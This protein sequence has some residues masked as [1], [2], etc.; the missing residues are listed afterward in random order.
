MASE[1]TIGRLCLY[2]RALQRIQLE[3]RPFVYSH[4]LAAET[5]VSAAQVRRDLM[6]IGYSGSPNRGYDTNELA[7]SIGERLDDPRGQAVA[8]VGVGN[9]GRA[10][11]SFV[12]RQRPGLEIVAAF[13]NNPDKAGRVIQG[14]RCHGFEDIGRVVAEQRILVGILTVPADAAQS[15]ADQLIA[16]GVTGLLNFAPTSLRVPP[17]VYVDQIDLTVSLERVAYFARRGTTVA[18]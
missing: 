18:R 9:L 5:G 17:H 2:R 16:A 10:I 8:L 14:C 3:G 12:S 4:Q 1:K 7:R 6:A 13:D 11:I 15:V